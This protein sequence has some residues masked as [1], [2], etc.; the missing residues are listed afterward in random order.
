MQRKCCNC[1]ENTPSDNAP[2]STT[3]EVELKQQRSK[4]NELKVHELKYECKKRQLAVSGSKNQILERLKPFE[5]VILTKTVARNSPKN[6][7]KNSRNLLKTSNSSHSLIDMSV[8]DAV[9]ANKTANGAETHLNSTPIRDVI[10]DY[11]LQNQSE[12]KFSSLILKKTTTKTQ[13][14]INNDFE[15]QLLRLNSTT[16]VIFFIYFFKKLI[17]LGKF[18]LYRRSGF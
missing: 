2:T 9:A 7:L 14:P 11:L 15:E 18:Y 5:D 1:N 13:D 3:I 4:L 8:I 16:S 6:N 12:K 10:N 17:F